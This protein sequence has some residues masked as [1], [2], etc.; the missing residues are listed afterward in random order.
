LPDEFRG[1]HS[2]ARI[3]V[4]EDGP[5]ARLLVD[6]DGAELG[7]CAAGHARV[8]EVDALPPQAGE[9]EAPR[10]VVSHLADV[11]GAQAEPLAG[12]ERRRYLPARLLGHCRHA[13]L[14][15]QGRELADY[16]HRVRGIQA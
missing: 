8:A 7:G 5:L 14:A 2:Q 15:A 1:P 11:A 16:Q 13:L 12:D 9:L 3:A 10:R 4:P 6:D